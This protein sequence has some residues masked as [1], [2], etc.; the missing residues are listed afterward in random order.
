MSLVL[1]IS[2]L[3]TLEY[4]VLVE[5]LCPTSELRGGPRDPRAPE[6]FGLDP[7]PRD[8]DYDPSHWCW[9]FEVELNAWHRFQKCGRYI[10]IW[11]AFRRR[12][13]NHPA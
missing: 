4:I 8:L 2:V 9:A 11:N 12:L 10:Q 7:N 6:S 1:L 5:E 3:R 13:I